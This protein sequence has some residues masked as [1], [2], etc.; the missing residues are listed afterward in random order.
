MRRPASLKKKLDVLRRRAG[1][2]DL[3]AVRQ[4]GEIYTHG[5]AAADGGYAVRPDPAKANAFEHQAMRLGDPW[6][7]TAVAD[8]ISRRSFKGANRCRATQLYC[9]AYRVGYAT[10]AYNLAVR[11]KDAGEYRASIAWFK[12]ALASGEE[13]ALL[14]LAKAELCGVGIRRNPAAAFEKLRRAALSREKYFPNSWYQCQAMIIMGVALLSGWSVR[15][16]VN[17]GMKWLARAR[18]LGSTVATEIAENSTEFT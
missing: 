11:Y 13:S 7:M 12:R 16:D 14:E 8:K 5:L 17:A 6:A 18:K 4:L 10:A 15:R 3:D 1:N 9:R 2:D